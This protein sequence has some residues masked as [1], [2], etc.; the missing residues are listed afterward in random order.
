MTGSRPQEMRALTAMPSVADRRPASRPSLLASPGALQGPRRSQKQCFW[1]PAGLPCLR[2]V[3]G[4]PPYSD[5]HA[6]R[7]PPNCLFLYLF[8]LGH[9]PLGFPWELQALSRDVDESLHNSAT[10]HF[11]QINE[12]VKNAGRDILRPSVWIGFVKISLKPA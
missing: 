2:F 3:K 4:A 7:G 10:P 9:W 1:G 12:N 8:C 6:L 11:Q 5:P